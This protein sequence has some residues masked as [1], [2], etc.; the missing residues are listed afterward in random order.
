LTIYPYPSI[1]SI[2]KINGRSAID[3]K[4]LLS[5]LLFL[6]ALFPFS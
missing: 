6:L 5:F 2:T 1:L 4:K 3:P